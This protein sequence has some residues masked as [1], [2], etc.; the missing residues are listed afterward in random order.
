MRLT[1]T[2]EDGTFG[3]ADELPCGENSHD[4]KKALIDTLGYYEELFNYMTM[5]EVLQ[6]TGDYKI[7]QLI[8]L[9]RAEANE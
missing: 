4:F 6:M 7:K 8:K 9:A 1:K 3:V 2:Y 5:D